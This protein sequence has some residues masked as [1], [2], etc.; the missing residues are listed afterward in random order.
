V[1]QTSEMTLG[2]ATIARNGIRLSLATVTLL[3]SSQQAP[4]ES[5]PDK[6]DMRPQAT[7]SSRVFDYVSD[8]AAHSR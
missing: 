4:Q 1:Q 5:A 6:F 7:E 3:T 8:L 2:I